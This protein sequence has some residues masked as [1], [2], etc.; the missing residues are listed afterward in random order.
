MNELKKMCPICV[1][2]SGTWIVLL[3]LRFADYD[4]SESFTALLMGGSVVGFSY[5]LAK[6]AQTGQVMFWKLLAIPIGFAAAWALLHFAW[7]FFALAALA[8]VLLWVIMRKRND[9]KIVAEKSPVDITKELED[10]CD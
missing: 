7:V 6:R 8:Y 2:V 4:I 9:P 3:A 5:T 10:C 1:L